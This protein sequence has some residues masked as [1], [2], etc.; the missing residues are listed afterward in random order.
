MILAGQ[1]GFV[2]V[3]L[4]GL[5]TVAALGSPFKYRDRGVGLVLVAVVWS[6][7][8]FDA[9]LGMLLFQWL[10]GSAAEWAFLIF[11]YLR[12]PAQTALFWIVVKSRRRP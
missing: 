8:L 10:T 6:M 7:L 9:M 1:I 3:V 12:V 2:L 11:L 4:S 5:V